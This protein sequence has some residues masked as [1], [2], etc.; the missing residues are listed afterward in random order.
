MCACVCVCDHTDSI[1]VCVTRSLHIKLSDKLPQIQAHHAVDD[2]LGHGGDDGVHDH[3]CINCHV[4]GELQG[5]QG[6]SQ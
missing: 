2:G 6:Q 5:S 3:A 4:G 1:S